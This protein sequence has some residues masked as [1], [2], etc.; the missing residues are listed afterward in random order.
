MR[1]Q[2]QTPG[3]GLGKGR[4]V[5]QGGRLDRQQ[6]CCRS[7]RAGAGLVSELLDWIREG[8]VRLATNKGGKW[9][10]WSPAARAVVETGRG[11]AGRLG[12]LRKKKVCGHIC[13]VSVTVRV[14]MYT[15][16][17]MGFGPNNSLLIH[18]QP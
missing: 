10:A 2:H 17:V 14:S 4:F 13:G 11:R 1:S 18:V 15:P 5:R 12:L 7:R 16:T 9:L 8:W 3:L 6:P